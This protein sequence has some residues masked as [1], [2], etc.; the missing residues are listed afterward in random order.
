MAKTQYGITRLILG[1]S[2]FV[3]L[4]HVDF[5][6][7]IAARRSLYEILY[8]EETFLFLVENY[9]D[10]ESDALSYT[11]RS[12]T[13]PK[14]SWSEMVSNIHLFNRRLINLLTTCRMYVD[15]TP[16]R[17]GAIFPN[18]AKPK[19]DFKSLLSSRYD[20]SFSFRLLEALRNYV[21]HN[22]LPLSGLCVGHQRIEETD[23]R[24]GSLCTLMFNIARDCILDGRRFKASVAD[25][26]RSM[27]DNIDVRPLIREY[28]GL[29]SE[30]HQELRK[31]LDE[32]LDEA[33]RV[34][35]A[36]V[37]SYAEGQEQSPNALYAV[38]QDSEGTVIAKHYLDCSPA[39][40]RNEIVE[41][42]SHLS[43]LAHLV[44]TSAPPRKA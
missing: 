29:L 30:V 28:V 24:P 10:L 32:P 31:T 12:A 8:I 40:R 39:K 33:V 4:S 11:L 19:S 22:D 27:P 15:H 3:P 21:Q 23:V 44:I 41:R 18:N 1:S 37:T 16:Q 9:R 35:D 13:F 17:L 36:A 7:L 25:E 2:R 14:E 6:H 26:L 38:E 5:D 20:S 34:V 43:S 42:Y